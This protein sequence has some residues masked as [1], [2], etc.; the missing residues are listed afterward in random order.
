MDTIPGSSLVAQACNAGDRVSNPGSGRAPGGGHG[1]PLQYSCLENPMV[2]G[3]WQT[4]VH[5]VAKS[6]TQLK[7]LSMHTFCPECFIGIS[8]EGDPCCKIVLHLTTY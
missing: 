2:S 7:Q 6:K 8:L 1:T 3:A 5:S 4:T